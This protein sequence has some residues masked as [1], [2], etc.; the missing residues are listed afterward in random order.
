MTSVTENAELA[1]SAQKK[2]EALLSYLKALDGKSA[3]AFSGGTDSALLAFAASRANCGR[4][5]AFTVWSP[6]LC[7]SDKK[8]I[9]RFTEEYGIE[10]VQIIFDE[11][12]L[13]DFCT[14]DSRRCY[15]CK[16][17]RLAALEKEAKNRGVKWILDGSNVD[18]LSDYRP[19]MEALRECRFAVS[20]LLECGFTK[21]E[22]REIS[23]QLGLPTAMKP[24]S[25]CLA[26][27]VPTGVAITLV[28]LETIEAGEEYL[29]SLLPKETQLRLR[30]D[31]R[32]AKI[33]TEG[34]YIALLEQNRAKICRHLAALG[35]A[36]VVIDKEGY[37]MGG[38]CRR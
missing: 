11:C 21:A 31:G 30:Y 28:L 18:D 20:P 17:G 37:K 1:G 22:I 34:A 36:R 3:V 23:R 27:R 15:T 35:I 4:S 8:E 13:G 16:A 19:G 32:C 2:Y 9:L 14:N 38:A 5:P 26:S 6:L 24:A 10:L 12:A 29:R 25:A 33:E 7:A